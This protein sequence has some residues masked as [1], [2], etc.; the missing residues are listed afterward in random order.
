MEHAVIQLDPNLKKPLYEQLYSYFSNA[1]RAGHLKAGEKLPSKRR[2]AQDTG[3]SIS[4]IET[5]YAMLTAEGY[6]EAK[7]RSG[8]RV[9][10]LSVLS[11]TCTVL[12]TH[13]PAFC[14]P[15]AFDFSTGS[16]DT[17]LFPFAAWRRLQRQ[18]LADNED[19]LQA[20]C[21]QGDETLRRAIATH[22]AEFRGVRAEAQQIVVGAGSEY[23]AGLLAQMFPHAIFAVEDP[24]YT[25]TPRVL[26]NCGACV[27]HVAIDQHGMQPVKLAASGARLA[28]VTPSHQFPTGAT[29]PI[30][31]R[32]Q[33]LQWAGQQDGRFVIE[34]D[35]DSEFRLDGRPLPALQGLGPDRV[36][37]LGTF[38]RSIAPA[39]RIGYLVLPPALVPEFFTRFGFYSCTVGR[40]EQQTLCRFLETGQYARH[41]SHLRN[42]Y[43]RKRDAVC[44][45]LYQ[46]LAPFDPDI[47]NAH[48]GLHFILRL[49]CQCADKTL[50]QAM[51]RHHVNACPLCAYLHSP[52][53]SASNHGPTLVIGFGGLAQENIL[54]AAQALAQAVADACRQQKTGAARK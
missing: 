33:L 51:Q 36:I 50:A 42:A 26:K 9:A 44:T 28:Y 23:L 15:T 2:L 25:R 54:P 45:A 37:Y 38:S 29:M 17:A 14:V 10:H 20:G 3:L 30:G 48:T 39:V 49:R 41:L 1:I 6:L 53:E 43:R 21:P 24:G 19:V 35:Y 7:P 4:T 47:K 31:R 34:D 46:A 13:T 11:H 8:F 18:V 22:L 27:A 52:Q 16:V 40:I 12:P 32:T 5:A